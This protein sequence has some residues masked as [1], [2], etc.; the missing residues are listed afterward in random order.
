MKFILRGCIE[1]PEGERL[2]AGIGD[3][4]CGGFEYGPWKVLEETYILVLQL[5]GTKALK[6]KGK[7]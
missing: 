3:Y 4:K 5:P 7:K 2:V 1:T 6:V